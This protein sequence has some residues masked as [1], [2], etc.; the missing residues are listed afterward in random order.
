MRKT[1]L[2]AYAS[3]VTLLVA[4]CSETSREEKPILS[5]EE[6]PQM[7]SKTFDGIE[8]VWIAG[9]EDGPTEE[10]FWMGKYEVT[11]EQWTAFM[12]TGPWWG[13]LR[14]L[15]KRVSDD[16]LTPAVFVSWHDAQAFAQR[17]G[18]QYRLPT[19]TEWEY[20]CRAGAETTYFFGEGPDRLG[21]YAWY[22][23]NCLESRNKFARPVGGKQPNPWGLH[24]MYGNVSEWCAGFY[25]DPPYDN[26]EEGDGQ[27]RAH[28]RVHRG[29]GW[30]SKAERCTSSTRT[31]DTAESMGPSVGFRLLRESE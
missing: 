17:L 10:G 16:P 4:G 9:S 11:K 29:G 27:R 2:C 15:E 5:V 21:E 13:T 20:A 7:I 22:R 31:G 30:G 19:E 28:H 26:V 12:G 18:P 14:K 6:S 8:F 24:D 23:D 25:D 1:L 3:A